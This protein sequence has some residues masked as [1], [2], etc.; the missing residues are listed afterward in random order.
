MPAAQPFY[1]G[2]LLPDGTNAIY[3]ADEVAFLLA[4]IP[5]AYEGLYAQR[6]EAVP[7][8]VDVD[9]GEVS[10]A[11]IYRRLTEISAYELLTRHFDDGIDA[12]IV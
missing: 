4:V 1:A 8:A 11:A 2:M 10:I 7:V 12:Y 3:V 5:D 6:G 9:G